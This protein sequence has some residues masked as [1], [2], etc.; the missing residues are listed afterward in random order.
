MYTFPVNSLG[1]LNNYP[2]NLDEV[3]KNCE[4]SMKRNSINYF[5]YSKNMICAIEIVR[6]TLE[7][8]KKI[9][10]LNGLTQHLHLPREK[11]LISENSTPELNV[12]Y[13]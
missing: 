10:L 1:N 13:F 7:S 12:T 8:T 9:I 2:A 4:T 11:F 6:L 3:I 5:N